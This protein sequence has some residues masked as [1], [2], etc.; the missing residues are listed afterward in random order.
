M[1]MKKNMKIVLRPS[2]SHF[3]EAYQVKK[4]VNSLEFVVGELIDTEYVA[5]L[6]A[7]KHWTVEIVS[8]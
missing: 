4:I 1:T 3:G 5:D 8:K 7:S 2:N 6:V